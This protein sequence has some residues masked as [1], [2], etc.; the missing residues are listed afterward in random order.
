MDWNKRS[1]DTQCEL[2]SRP[3]VPAI[4]LGKVKFSNRMAVEAGIASI[5]RRIVTVDP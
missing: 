5:N 2:I 4:L 1:V 3:F